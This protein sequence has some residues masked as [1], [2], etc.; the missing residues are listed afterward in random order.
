MIEKGPEFHLFDVAFHTSRKKADIDHI[1]CKLTGFFHR[2]NLLRQV[3]SKEVQ[4]T[5]EGKANH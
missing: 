2:A 3:I 5:V 1:E 4:I